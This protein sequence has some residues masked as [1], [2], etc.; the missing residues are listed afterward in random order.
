M[1][2]LPSHRERVN[3][4][5]YY[6]MAENGQVGQ[7]CIIIADF[8]NGIKCF[9]T[10]NVC[11]IGVF[12]FCF[13]RTTTCS[14]PYF[15]KLAPVSL[16]LIHIWIYR[17]K[18]TPKGGKISQGHEMFVA[19]LHVFVPLPVFPNAPS[20]WSLDGENREQI[21][22]MSASTGGVI[23]P[24]VP[25]RSFPQGTHPTSQLRLYIVD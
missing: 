6:S 3:N 20:S 18:V 13:I 10:L 16:V 15:S 19:C 24:P 2:L 22:Y 23:M 5:M 14:V 8:G 12:H 17:R 9:I 1:I 7:I 21:S 25:P 4:S 11:F